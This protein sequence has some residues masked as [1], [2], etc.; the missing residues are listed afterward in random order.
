MSPNDDE[1]TLPISHGPSV[2]RIPLPATRCE[3]GRANFQRLPRQNVCCC[4]QCQCGPGDRSRS[5]QLLRRTVQ[6][7]QLRAEQ[8]LRAQR[9]Q[10]PARSEEH[11]SELQSLMRI[12]YAV[13]CLKKKK[14]KSK[15]YSNCTYSYDTCKIL[16][17]TNLQ[18]AKKEHKT[19]T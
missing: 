1:R 11:T 14:T 17:K 6:A 10:E 9:F 7:F 12:S 19:Y 8:P 3:A 5:R 16:Q 18:T 13:F 4:G 2:L 15:T